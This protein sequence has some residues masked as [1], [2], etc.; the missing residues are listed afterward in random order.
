MKEPE[1][2]E[3]I[4]RRG[5]NE[6]RISI[7]K[8]NFLSGAKKAYSYDRRHKAVCWGVLVHNLT[9]LTRMLIEKELEA[10]A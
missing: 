7:V 4:K 10:A 3:K 1:F 6:G 8:N 5:Q 9:K 2:R